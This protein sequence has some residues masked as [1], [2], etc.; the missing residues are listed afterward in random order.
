ML[1][2]SVLVL[3][4]MITRTMMTTTAIWTS[5]CNFKAYDLRLM[6]SLMCP[7]GS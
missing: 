6:S 4:A 1:A 7:E 3:S 2:S 5:D